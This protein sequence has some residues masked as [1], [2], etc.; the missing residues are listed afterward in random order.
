VIDP[1]NCGFAGKNDMPDWDTS[2][3]T[4]MDHLFANA[5]YVAQ[6][7]SQIG[8]K[9]RNDYERNVCRS[10]LRYTPVAARLQS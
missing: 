5:N 7:I 6:D 1:A 10:I 3:V 9:F 4:V 2:G 8:H